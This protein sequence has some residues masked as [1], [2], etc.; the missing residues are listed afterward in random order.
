MPRVDRMQRCR[1]PLKARAF[2]SGRSE[3]G[4]LSPRRRRASPRPR[5][6]LSNPCHVL[7][8]L[9][10]TSPSSAGRSS[11]PTPSVG[12]LLVAGRLGSSS[13]VVAPSSSSIMTLRCP[14]SRPPALVP[15]TPSVEP[16]PP[17]RALSGEPLLPEIP[18]LGYPHCCVALAVVPDPS[19]RR[20]TPES[21]QP[22]PPLLRVP[23]LPC[24]CVGHTSAAAPWG[25]RRH[26]FRGPRQRCASR[27]PRTVLM[28]RVEISPLT[29]ICFSK[30]SI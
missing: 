19:C 29:L 2:R 30:F 25:A 14:L 17:P 23:T 26:P 20:P 12:A 4:R 13:G 1:T 5:R 9:P 27:P 11:K 8:S 7:R 22:P 24:H 18:Q 15:V 21:G 28:G 3:R 16:P 6:E 10:L